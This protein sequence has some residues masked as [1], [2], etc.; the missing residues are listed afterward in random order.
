MKKLYI[1][2]HAK[3]SWKN[4]DLSDF[5]RPLNKRGKRNA[6]FMGEL[7][8]GMAIMPNL[9]VSSP[10]ERAKTTAFT[11]SEIIGYNFDKV[12]FN[13]SIYE[14]GLFTL[15]EIVSNFS[16][17][18]ESVMIFGHNPGF[19]S[20]NNFLSNKYIDNIPTSGIVCLELQIDSWKN[21]S[22]KCGKQVFYE[23]PKKHS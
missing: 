6:P 21:L 23:Y 8:K 14:S 16:D 7:L 1:A 19:T 15:K 2:R 13:E 22:E 11:V 3:S 20:L 12:K 17:E 4:P 10:A 9:V 18:F 5:E